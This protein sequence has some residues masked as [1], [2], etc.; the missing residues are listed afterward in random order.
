MGP[1]ASTTF[2]IEYSA[3]VPDERFQYAHSIGWVRGLNGS[4]ANGGSG[5]L[6]TPSPSNVGKPPALPANSGTN[7]FQEMLTRIDPVTGV[8]T[9]LEKCSFAVT[10]FTYSKTT[11]GEHFGYPHDSETA[12]FALEIE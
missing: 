3:Y 6:P 8:V 2:G 12:A 11:N 7:T 5:S 1:P 9:V 10:L 4:A